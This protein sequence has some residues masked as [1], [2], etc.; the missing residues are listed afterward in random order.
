MT[1]AG[2]ASRM[3]DPIKGVDFSSVRIA[4]RFWSSMISL[5]QDKTIPACLDRCAETGRIRNFAIAA[6]KSEGEY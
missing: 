4:D 6:G 1:R 5:V 3:D 2:G